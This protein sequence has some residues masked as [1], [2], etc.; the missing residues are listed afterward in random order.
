[1]ELNQEL[2]RSFVEKNSRVERRPFSARRDLRRRYARRVK[3]SLINRTSR[4]EVGVFD[5]LDASL[6]CEPSTAIGG[7][8]DFPKRCGRQPLSEVTAIPPREPF[9]ARVASTA[10][11]GP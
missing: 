2:E 6:L 11:L 7:S 5:S 10:E 1:M 8:P 4:Q 3:S 9:G